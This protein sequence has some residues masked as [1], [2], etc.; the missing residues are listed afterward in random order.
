MRNAVI[1]LSLLALLG[2]IIIHNAQAATPTGQAMYDKLCEASGIK[3]IQVI[4]GGPASMTDVDGKFIYIS[5][6]DVVNYCQR[7]ARCVA[8]IV[9]HEI[10]HIYY[11]HN[12]PKVTIPTEK[13][14]DR[15]ALTLLDKV[16]ISAEYGLKYQ[17]KKQKDY[18]DSG[19]PT[20]PD[21]SWRIN[22]VKQHLKNKEYKNDK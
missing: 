20:H 8:W 3:G 22:L 21:W 1:Y 11:N 19:Y 15:Y 5:A 12:G 4:T 13:Q 2:T 7:D 9:S 14:A 17:Y 18:G 16:G 6:D 10:G